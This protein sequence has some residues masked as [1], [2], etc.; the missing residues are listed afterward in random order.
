MFKKG[1]LVSA[2]SDKG[3]PMDWEGIGVVVD[4]PRRAALKGGG[5]AW[6]MS[7]LTPTG[8]V[9]LGWSTEDRNEWGHYLE[10]VN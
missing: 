6:E 4:R 8:I 1:D 9:D 3:F 10:V 7:V 5:C 2:Y